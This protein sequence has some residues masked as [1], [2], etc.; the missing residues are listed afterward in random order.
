MSRARKTR[1]RAETCGSPDREGGFSVLEA[2]VAMA[3]LAAAFLPLLEL[4]AR[5]V[6]ATDGLERATLR[7]ADRQMAMEVAASI[8][9]A[10]QPAGD[11]VLGRKRLRWVSKPVETPRSVRTDY[12]VPTRFNAG[13]YDV[14]LTVSDEQGGGQSTRHTLR[15]LGWQPTESVFD[16]AG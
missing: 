12:G 4:Q 6:S 15:G 11:Y 16:V 5:F 9:F 1:P 10:A 3:L 14:T 7:M 2:L 13:L 8:N